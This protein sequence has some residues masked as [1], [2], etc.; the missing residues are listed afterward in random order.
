MPHVVLE[1]AQSIPQAFQA[2]EPLALKTDTGILKLGDK[3]INAAENSVLIEALAIEQGKNQSFFIQLSQKPSSITVR[4][5]PLTDPEKSP[6]V[7]L[8]MARVAKQIKDSNPAIIYG[9]TNLQ[10]YLLP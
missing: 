9:K 2:I 5:L 7:K 1:Q 8:L 10:D 3:Y 6:G 4:L